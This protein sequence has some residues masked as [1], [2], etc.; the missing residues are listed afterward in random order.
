MAQLIEVNGQTIE[1]PDGMPVGDIEAAIKKN[2]L[3][4]PRAKPAPLSTL[5]AKAPDP[6]DD[7]GAFDK[8]AAGAG[9]A[10]ADLGRSAGQ[11][12]RWLSP[13]L[14]DAVGAPTDADIAE[15]H[16]L[17]ASLMDTGAGMAGNIAGN[18]AM[19]LAPGT[20]QLGAASKI[21]NLWKAGG[22]ASRLGAVGGAAGMGAVQNAVFN[23]R[24]A[25][26]SLQGQLGM[27]AAMGAGGQVAG[28]LLAAGV[29]G[30]RNIRAGSL[31]TAGR[32]LQ[33]FA[34]VDPA[35]L[36]RLIKAGNRELIPGS[37]PTTVQAT[38]NAGLARLKAA[39]GGMYPNSFAGVDAQQ[40]AA[41]L[42]ALDRIAPGS[43]GRT[44]IDAAE[45]AG[46]VLGQEA[47]L[48]RD[49]LKG[50]VREQYNHPSLN[51]A[52]IALPDQGSALSVLNQFYPGQALGADDQGRALAAFAKRLDSGEPIP[53][54]EFDALR[55]IASNK[56][57]DLADTDRTAAA[58]WGSL[59]RLFNE[60]EEGAV[61]KSGDKFK[62]TGQGVDGPIY[63]NLRGDTN[64]AVAHLLRMRQG[65][66][67]GALSHVDVKDP[68]DLVWGQAGTGN[69]DGFGVSKLAEFHPEALPDLQGLLNRTAVR[70]EASG[71]NRIRLAGKDGEDAAVSL[72]WRGDPK[73]WLLSAFE[74]SPENARRSMNL[75]GALGEGAAASPPAALGQS[76]PDIEAAFKSFDQSLQPPVAVRDPRQ[77]V[78]GLLAPDQA[79]HLQAGRQLHGE[80]Q[81][82]FN[83]GPA[84][85]LTRTGS[86]G[87]PRL[88]GAERIKAFVNSKD[89]QGAD[90]AQ[91]RKMVLDRG[92]T[93]QAAK[94]YA[95]SDLMESATS[96]GLLS[97]TKFDNWTNR[98]SVMLKGLLDTGERA[99]LG[100]VGDDLQR[101]A[102]ADALERVRGQSNTAEKL[103]SL[104][105]LDSKLTDYAMKGLSL[106][107][108]VGGLLGAGFDGSKEAVK[109][110]KYKDVPEALLDPKKALEALKV[111]EAL[112][113]QNMLQRGLLSPLIQQSMVPAMTSG[114]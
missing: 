26:D 29:Q 53:L 35:E 71:P 6:T 112:R 106:L 23:P 104:G 25:E 1:F 99:Q 89:S 69:K 108:G 67:P 92:P 40:N 97:P 96:G 61:A 75:S 13:K 85:L 33:D 63:G 28:P 30:V 111:Q 105:L 43:K 82:R 103:T 7:M 77:Y 83:T 88:Q 34:G 74:R 102:S 19:S 62:V 46:D 81:D 90:M 56:A 12:V 38:Q 39:M 80:L 42:A 17:D 86:D 91:L 32:T 27:G 9:K 21:N 36:T 41:R 31:G 87:A 65:E 5:K 49:T 78:G 60:A 107:P 114:D 52:S 2:F 37:A 58:A 24:G 14:A 79:Q 68:I 50:L 22:V 95:L 113:Q 109:R 54:K 10:V 11:G 48:H 110:W 73:T 20:G 70:P 18:I 76:L 93:M 64:N 8:F 66:V 72:N 94:G 47:A 55:K 16:R 101:A 15:S 100:N 59:K 98:R 84:S 45:N 51:T 4:I 3:S 57:A 44:A